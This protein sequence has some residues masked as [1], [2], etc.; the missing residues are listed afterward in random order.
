MTWL[1]LDKL[2]YKYEH[3]HPTHRVT[4]IFF[5]GLDAPEMYSG[6]YSECG[7]SHGKPGIRLSSGEMVSF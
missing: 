3:S 2:V 7:L 4:R 6:I 1:E 5:D